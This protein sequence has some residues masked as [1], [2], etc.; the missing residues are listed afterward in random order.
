[1]PAGKLLHMHALPEVQSRDPA[2]REPTAEPLLQVHPVELLTMSNGM[3]IEL[4]REE[5]GRF[6]GS[7]LL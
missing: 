2:R 5:L 1:M 6:E 3:G 4:Y 7:E